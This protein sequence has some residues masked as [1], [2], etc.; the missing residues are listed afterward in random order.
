MIHHLRLRF[1]YPRFLPKLLYVSEMSRFAIFVHSIVSVISKLITY[2][3]TF[4]STLGKTYLQF[5]N[6]S[7][8]LTDEE[9]SE[10]DYFP[11]PMYSCAIPRNEK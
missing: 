5:V 3:G 2:V 1:P 4:I 10:L 6:S 7:L 8:G 9:N 11:L